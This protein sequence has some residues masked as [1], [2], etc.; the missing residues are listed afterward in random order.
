MDMRPTSG[1]GVGSCGAVLALSIWWAGAG[2]A[3]C[4][5]DGARFEEAEATPVKDYLYG[6]STAKNGLAYT[7]LGAFDAASP[8][9]AAQ[10]AARDRAGLPFDQFEVTHGARL[11][12]PAEEGSATFTLFRIVERPAAKGQVQFDRLNVGRFFTLSEAEAAAAA[13]AAVGGRFEV[14]FGGYGC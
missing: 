5:D 7:Y 8:M 1:F 4:P 13:I 9:A 3:R 12:L 11:A 14:V 2:V 6:F 10:K